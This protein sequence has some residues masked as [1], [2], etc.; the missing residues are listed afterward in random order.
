MSDVYIAVLTKILANLAHHRGD[1]T[2]KASMYCYTRLSPYVLASSII[3]H[4]LS[5]PMCIDWLVIA[6]SVV[7]QAVSQDC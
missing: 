1:I 3:Y 6:L 5:E 7:A 2:G 4:G